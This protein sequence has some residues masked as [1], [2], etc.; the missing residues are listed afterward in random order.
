L[1]QR[2]IVDGNYPHPAPLFG[3]IDGK[4]SVGQIEKHPWGILQA[5]PLITELPVELDNHTGNFS[6]AP[7]A[8]LLQFEREKAGR[9]GEKT[10]SERD[11]REYGPEGSA[12]ESPPGLE[13]HSNVPVPDGLL[14]GLQV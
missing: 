10:Q 1:F 11:R 13:S 6:E 4:P 8:D 14:D 3:P 5:G 2:G 12:F 7:K 9:C